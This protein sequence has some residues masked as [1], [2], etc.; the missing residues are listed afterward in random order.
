MAACEGL[1]SFNERS[2]FCNHRAYVET[3][4]FSPE[5]QM[6][7]SKTILI[8]MALALAGAGGGIAVAETTRSSPTATAPAAQSAGPVSAG[9]ATISV[10]TGTVAG[11]SEQVLVDAQGLALYTYGPDTAT[12]SHV[13]GALAQLWPPLVS[14]LPTETGATG[15]LSVVADTNGQQVQYNGHFLY[16]FV[17]DTPGQITGQGVQDFFVATPHLGAKSSPASS[18]PTPPATTHTNPYGY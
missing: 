12:Q 10:A 17:N 11:K 4:T 18:I 13:S 5:A 6:R 14:S 15:K 9:S 2:T 1:V 8:V 16:T 7:R 3:A